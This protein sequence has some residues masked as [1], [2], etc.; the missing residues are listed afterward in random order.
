MI[1]FLPECNFWEES[2]WTVI[3]FARTTEVPNQ[4]MSCLTGAVQIWSEE[5]GIVKKH[6]RKIESKDIG[7]ILLSIAANSSWIVHKNHENWLWRDEPVKNCANWPNWTQKL[8]IKSMISSL[9][10]LLLIDIGNNRSWL[11]MTTLARNVFK[12]GKNET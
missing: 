7:C 8:H 2:T 5:Q 6:P 11:M 12:V 10:D 1:A 4:S 3:P 9:R